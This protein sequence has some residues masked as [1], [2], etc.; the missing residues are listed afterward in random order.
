[1]TVWDIDS[2]KQVE[3]ILTFASQGPVRELVLENF[4][5]Y[6]LVKADPSKGLCSS[7][8]S[9]DPVILSWNFKNARILKSKKSRQ[10]SN[11]DI[12]MMCLYGGTTG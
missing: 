9:Q 12:I 1:M 3:P 6:A 7:C 2:Q 4:D 10:L 5:I 8:N 11:Q